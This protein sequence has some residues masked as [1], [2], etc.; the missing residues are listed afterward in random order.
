M[1]GEAFLII[2]ER[3]FGVNVGKHA[4]V[5]PGEESGTDGSEEGSDEVDL[6]VVLVSSGFHDLSLE[7]VESN[8][9]SR[10]KRSSGVGSSNEDHGREGGGDG[11]ASHPSVAVSGESGSGVLDEEVS[12]DEDTGAHGFDHEGL[13]VRRLGL[14][15]REFTNVLGVVF[16]DKAHVEEL[17]SE[18]ASNELGGEHVHE[19]DESLH[20]PVVVDEDTNRDSGVVVGSGDWSSQKK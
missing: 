5:S 15:G 17:H 10:V 2:S 3:G 16:A 1:R 19:L 14:E 9:N 8:G 20:V 11:E 18:K 13:P 4:A 7:A 12:H 6:K